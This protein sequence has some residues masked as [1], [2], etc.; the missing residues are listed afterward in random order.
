MMVLVFGGTGMLGSDVCRA[1]ELREHEVEAPRHNR[2]DIENLKELR[3]CVLAVKPNAVVNCAAL[4]DC[5]ECE[6]NPVSALSVNSL[7]V[8]YMATLCGIVGARFMTVSTD[9]V[10]DGTKPEGYTEDD[11]TDP[12]NRYGETKLLGEIYATAQSKVF[13]VRVQNLYGLAPCRGKGKGLVDAIIEKSK[14]GANAYVD[15]RIAAPTWT[16]PLA[17]NM[18]RLLETE[19]YG[20]Y[21]MSCQGPVSWFAFARQ[22]AYMLGDKCHVEPVENNY[23][24]TT[25]RRPENTYLINRNLQRVGMD[26]MP[27]WKVALDDYLRAR[28]LL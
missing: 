18:V 20:L 13:V 2:V 23:I 24:K 21:H 27:D 26:Y 28:G 15:Q 8:S 1:L 6:R 10:F 9:Y 3:E 14:T 12:V 11:E 5:A 7:A 16:Y 22:L 25:F 4:H 19:H 17:E